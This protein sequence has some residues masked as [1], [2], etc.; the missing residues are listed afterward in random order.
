MSSQIHFLLNDCEICMSAHPGTLV[1]DFLRKK[2]KLM[3]TKEGCKE[4]D[5]GACTVLVGELTQGKMHYKPV[6][7]CLMPLG[8]LHG[9]HLVTVEG[10]NL[11]RLTPVQQAIVDLGATQCGFCTPGIVVSM[12]GLLMQEGAHIDEAGI[13]KAL[14]G[15]LC[16]CTGYR[17]LK[18]TQE[19]IRETIGQH[20]GIEALIE[21][22]WLPDYFRKIPA[23]LRKIAGPGAAN[24][25]TMPDFFIAGGTDLY[26]QKGEL[27]PESRVQVLNLLPEMK[28]VAAKN[29][30]L[31]VGALTTF[32]EFAEHPAVV[33]IIPNI[34]EYMHLIAS[35]QIRNRATLGGNIINASPIGDLTILLLAL[36]SQLVLQEGK[37]RRTVP[38]TAF[39]RGYKQ[40]EKRPEEI[41]TEI[42]IPK[43][44][45]NI[46]IHFE[47]VSK[48][49]CLDIASVNSA[50]RVRCEAEIIREVGLAVGGVAPVP[51]FLKRTCQFL[52]GKPVSKTTIQAA[53]A[54]AQREIAPINDIR[55]SAAYKRLLTRQLLIG[56]FA[57]LFPELV[58]VREFY[59][60]H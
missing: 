21:H 58:K 42:L 16:R 50:I 29:G 5:C 4:G 12:T 27:L 39:Y 26:V 2:E 52:L 13:K 10:L 31:R 20:T 28:G 45:P 33:Q 40:L 32:E 1:L 22:Q 56:H 47:K 3:G 30:G 17:S 51:L 55:G 15:H 53:F 35:W 7:S 49:K 43:P 48:R 18:Q 37:E 60:T 54:V 34:Q 59:E 57:R 24:G 9:K 36:E 19:D 23:C 46:R 38:L 6:T 8:E 14:S 41:L 11:T 25:K 44:Q